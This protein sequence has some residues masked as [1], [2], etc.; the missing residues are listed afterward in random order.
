MLICIA[1]EFGSGGHEIGK[2]LAEKL[3]YRFYDRALVTEAGRRSSISPELLEKADERRVNPWLYSIVYDDADQ[4]LRGISANEAM[5]RMQSAMILE[6]AKAGDC[7]FVGRC[8][9]EVLKQAGMKRLSIFITAPFEVRVAR[10]KEIL[11]MEEKAV[12]SLVR[13]NDKQRRNYY[14]YYT[15]G[16]WGKPCSYDLCINS[17]VF[18]I[19]QTAEALAL[20]AEKGGRTNLSQKGEEAYVEPSV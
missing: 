18:G 7:V 16:D 5:F 12:A 3:G 10:K 2:L 8:A 11:N 13:K 15:S 1:R 4:E 14:N 19:E 6:A 9:D 17:A 20:L